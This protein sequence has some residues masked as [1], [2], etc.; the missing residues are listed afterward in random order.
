MG[1]VDRRHDH[2]SG[3]LLPMRSNSSMSDAPPIAC[4]LTAIPSAERPR[5][6]ALRAQVLGT[7]QNV[8]E[9]ATASSCTSAPIATGSSRWPVE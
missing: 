7:L 3:G 9:S 8:T 6:F 4:N 1:Q 5:Y 2:R